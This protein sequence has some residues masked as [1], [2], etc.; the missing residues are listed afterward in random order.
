MEKVVKTVTGESIE[1]VIN[2]GVE[3]I[4]RKVSVMLNAQI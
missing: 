2:G 1:L 4:K 3:K